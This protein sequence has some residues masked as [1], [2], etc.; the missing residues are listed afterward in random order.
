MSGVTL[1]DATAA[2]HAAVLAL[3]NAATPH[4]N[5]L[6]ADDLT[7]LAEQAKHFRLAEDAEGLA[8]FVLC[9]PA[10]CGYWSGN[11]QWF[12]DRYDDFLYLDRVV[13]AAR[14]RRSGVGRMLYD[15]VHASARGRWPRV[16]LEVNLRPPN[17]TSVA[18]HAALGYQPVGI[19]EYDEGSKAVQMY[20]RETA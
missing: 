19:R 10:G 15:D 3:N 16:A 11:Y 2:D 20:I 5:A 17:P 18:F 14:S 4:V 12:A 9:L 8:G 13:V 1:R 7:W 6:S